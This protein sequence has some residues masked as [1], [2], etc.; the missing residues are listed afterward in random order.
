MR[1]IDEQIKACTQRYLKTLSI[2]V[3]NQKE[4]YDRQTLEESAQ[5]LQPLILRLFGV[6]IMLSKIDTQEIHVEQLVNTEK[7]M[8]FIGLYGH[9]NIQEVLAENGSI[10]S[11]AGFWKQ[12]LSADLDLLVVRVFGLTE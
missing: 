11:I 2:K 3:D 10:D 12:Q 8:V 1:S 7:R 6:L 9:Q 4:V 5:P